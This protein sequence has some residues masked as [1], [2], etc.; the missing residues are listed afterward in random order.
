MVG[1][2]SPLEQVQRLFKELKTLE[3]KTHG[4][5]PVPLKDLHKLHADIK[6]LRA[7]IAKL[8]GRVLR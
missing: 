6:K 1:F 7:Q 5:K 4:N 2:A 3:D 8:E